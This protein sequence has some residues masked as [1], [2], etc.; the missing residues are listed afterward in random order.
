MAPRRENR[1]V[2]C[3]I[4]AALAGVALAS[5]GLLLS[6]C[7]TTRAVVLPMN[8]HAWVIDCSGANLSWSHCY[9]EAG[10]VCPT[11]Y[12]VTQKPWKHDEHVVAGDLLQ[13]VG[14]SADHRRMLIECRAAAMR[15]PPHD[16]T[17]VPPYDAFR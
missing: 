8:P 6:A 7:T 17:R 4:R 16:A 9:S 15:V 13:F 2:A 11:G 10:H 14:D 1:P 5:C 3:R 12:K